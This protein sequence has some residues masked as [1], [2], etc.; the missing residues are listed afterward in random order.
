MGSL[1]MPGPS[2]HPPLTEKERSKRRPTAGPRNRA[3]SKAQAGKA[4]Q[5]KKRVAGPH[6]CAYSGPVAR[7]K[8]TQEL[9]LA[10][11]DCQWCSL[12][13]G[14]LVALDLKRQKT[15]LHVDFSFKSRNATFLA[16]SKSGFRLK[17]ELTLILVVILKF[18]GHFDIATP[19]PLIRNPGSEF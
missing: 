10:S 16:K 2:V 3:V 11:R 14:L 12:Q 6:P 7:P 13:E 9:Q 15:G 1:T 17:L 19:P 4:A 5:G 18:Q 8:S